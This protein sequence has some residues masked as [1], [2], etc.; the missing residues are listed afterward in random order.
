MEHPPI[1]VGDVMTRSVVAVGRDARFKEMVESLQSWHISALPVLA[2]DGRVVGVVSE[3]D[4]L[5]KEEGE[6]P[7]AGAARSA[8]RRRLDKASG[9]TAGQLMSAPAIT[10]HADA[11]LQQAARIMA[12]GHVKRLP[13]TDSEGHL[14]GVVSR[15]DLLK[16]YLRP[17]REITEEVRQDV[18]HRLLP[19]GS[20][21]IG[22]TV[23]EGVVALAGTV[24][25]PAVAVLLERLVRAVPGVVDVDLQLT[26]RDLTSQEQ[27]LST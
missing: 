14:R 16:V 13:V 5:T 26:V 20:T 18:L 11:T 3:A 15:G 12:H 7:P 2:G 10:V 17:D 19:A 4:L 27:H 25:D 9:V 6:G 23:E 22:V 21:N 1:T 24:P 8:D